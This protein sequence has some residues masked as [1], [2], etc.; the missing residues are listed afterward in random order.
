MGALRAQRG[1][2]LI[3]VLLVLVIAVAA[4]THTI[5][6]N[7]I[8]VTRT[9][10]LLANAQL[11]EFVV[12]AE[13]WARI[14]LE[15]DFE[16]DKELPVSADTALE[17]WSVPALSFNPDNGKIRINIKDLNSCFN[18]NNLASAGRESE[19]KQIFERLVRN[20]T[21][22]SDLARAIQDWVD[23]G[24][25]P[26]APGTEDDGYLGREWA[27]RTPDAPITDIS[28]LSAVTGMEPEDWRALRPYL[29]A[30]PETGTAI[31]VN[32]APAE[33]LSAIEPQ[34]RAAELESFREADGVFTE[35]SQLEAYGLNGAGGLVFHSRYF[36]ARIA[37]QLGDQ[38]DHQQYWESLL[39]LDERRGLVHVVQRQRRPFAMVQMGELLGETA[40]EI[41]QKSNEIN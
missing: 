38:G 27:H 36:L 31:N 41:S 24:D 12:G 30:L 7:R 1:V 21:G 6:R 5:T 15:R 2:A 25:T 11:A 13:A 14:A 29:C 4:L 3:T 28:E 18:V 9:S 23:D 40:S 22:K 35:R 26:L 19:Q 20:L 17:S 34:A 39:Q 10:A 32:F 37:V 16:Q 33:L 8:A